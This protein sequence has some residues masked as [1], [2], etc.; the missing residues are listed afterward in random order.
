MSSAKFCVQAA[1]S[2]EEPELASGIA[3]NSFLVIAQSKNKPLPTANGA[4]AVGLQAGKG[5][6]HPGP[7]SK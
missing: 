2:E 1:P 4:Q 3:L 6:G 5:D 7:T